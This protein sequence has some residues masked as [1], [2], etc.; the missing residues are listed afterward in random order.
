MTVQ[1]SPGTDTAERIL[2]AATQL[3]DLEGAEAVS[4]RRVA[5]GVGIT[6]M[7][8]Y[9][10][11][12]NREGLLNAITDAGFVEMRERLLAAGGRETEPRLTALLDVWLDFA[13]EKPRLFELMFLTL[14]PGARVFPEDFR[15]GASPTAN[16]AAGLIDEGMRN[17]VFRRDDVWEITLEMG[18]LLQGMVMLYLGG[19]IGME[20]EEFRALCHRSFR[21]YFDGIRT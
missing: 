4:M 8:V 12:P 2:D 14:R 10:H 17:G 13:L 11:F 3:L 15:A 1:T 7:A 21:R 9:R 5:A 18:A 20:A 6:A 16:I 19:R